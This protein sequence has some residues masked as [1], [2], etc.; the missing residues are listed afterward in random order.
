MSIISTILNVPDDKENHSGYDYNI[1]SLR[2][3]DPV[4]ARRG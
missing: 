4:L 3:L 2:K 1:K